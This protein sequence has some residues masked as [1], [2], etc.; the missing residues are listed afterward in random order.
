MNL[1]VGSYRFQDAC[2]SVECD[3][4]MRPSQLTNGMSDFAAIATT[5]IGSATINGLAE[6]TSGNEG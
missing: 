3:V 1:Q 6:H 2:A 4:Q 5:T